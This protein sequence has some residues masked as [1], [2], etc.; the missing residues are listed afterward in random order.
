MLIATI[1]HIELSLLPFVIT[2][3]YVMDPYYPL[4]CIHPLAIAL[5]RHAVRGWE[6]VSV[7]I[8]ILISTVHPVEVQKWR[9]RWF[10]SRDT[11]RRPIG[12]QLDP[13]R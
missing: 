11:S 9:R 7:I 4:R 5:Y 10:R 2:V 13:R 6:A 3:L 12:P 8:A 1:T